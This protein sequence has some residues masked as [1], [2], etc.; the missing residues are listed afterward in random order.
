MNT[1]GDDLAIS[2]LEDK[3]GTL[4]RALTAIAKAGINLGGCAQ[5]EGTLH[6]LSGDPT[7]TRA[8]L[9]GA[10]FTV[11][12][13]P[14]LVVD[15]ADQPGAA[16]GIFQHLADNGINVDFTYVGTNNRLVI[17]TVDPRKAAASLT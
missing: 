8:A 1:I 10:G 12:E 15:V 3:P 16:A 6:V 14:V 7:A 13:A 11:R 17:G 5:I 9:K 2:L 4:A